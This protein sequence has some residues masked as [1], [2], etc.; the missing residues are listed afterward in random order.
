[1]VDLLEHPEAGP[2]LRSSIPVAGES[3]TLSEAFLDTG[4]EGHLHAKTGRLNSVIGLAGAV[5]DG[6]EPDIV[7]AYLVNVP[8][9]QMAPADEVTAAQVRLGTILLHHPDV[10]SEEKLGP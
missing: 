7:F 1:V 9:G 3:G 8:P 10:P 5:V 6:E 4:L 2:T